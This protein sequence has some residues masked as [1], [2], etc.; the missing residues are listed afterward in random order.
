LALMDT[1][2]QDYETFVR[3]RSQALLRS[4]YL[5]TGDQQLAEDLVQE[6]L[7]RT[8]R[9]WHRLRETGN[10]EAYAR[11][12]MYNTQV[13]IWRR[14]RFTEVSVGEIPEP[15]SGRTADHAD[16]SALRITLRNALRTL[17]PKQRAVVVL[18]YFDG[19][20]E[21]EAAEV[22][23]V[24]VSTVKTQSSR[25]LDRLRAIVPE[26]GRFRGTEGASR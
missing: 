6:A 9:A 4:A 15:V 10:A 20:T 19:H 16:A 17:G 23:G 14:R 5:L 3:G 25:A 13:S 18:R 22:L 2:G 8:Y 7:A 1:R 24:S 12:V 21:K 26:L 11:K